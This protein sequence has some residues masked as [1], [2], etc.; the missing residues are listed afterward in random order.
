MDIDV[1][2]VGTEHTKT[3]INIRPREWPLF[4]VHVVVYVV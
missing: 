2:E 1:Q 3:L 4:I